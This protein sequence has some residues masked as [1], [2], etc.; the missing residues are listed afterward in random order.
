MYV[1]WD[2][3]LTVWAGP[4]RSQ[5]K[6]LLFLDLMI[7]VYARELSDLLLVCHFQKAQNQQGFIGMDRFTLWHRQQLL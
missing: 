3:S 5:K 7:Q 2:R 4:N 6:T 1:P